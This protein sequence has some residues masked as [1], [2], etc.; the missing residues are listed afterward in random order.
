M[1]HRFGACSRLR[2]LPRGAARSS[3]LAAAVLAAVVASVPAQ[4]DP[5]LQFAE[6][7]KRQL[8]TDAEP[9]VAVARGDVDGDGDLD[10]VLASAFRRSRLYRNDGRGVF[11]DATA[12]RLPI[13]SGQGVSALALGDVDGDSDLD[14]VVGS[15]SQQSELYLN[16]GSGTFADATRLRMPVDGGAR[17]VVLGD[18]DGDGDLDL[19]VGDL[20]Q[21]RIYVNNGAGVFADATAVRMPTESETAFALALG[22]V[23]GDGDLDLI[24]AN[25]GQDRLFVNNGS[26][27][28]VDATSRWLPVDNQIA[29]A[30]A[31]GDVDG[32]GDLDLVIGTQL[33]QKRLYR[34]DG[35]GTFADVTAGRMPVDIDNTRAVVFGDVDGDGDLDLLLGNGENPGDGIAGQQNRLYRNDGTGTFTDATAG[36]LPVAR[37]LTEAAVLGDFD[38]D[39]DLDLVVGNRGQDQLHLNDGSGTF[40]DATTGR[41]PADVGAQAVALGDVDGDGD[42]D[43][44]LGS[45]NYPTGQQNRLFRNDGAGGFTDATANRLPAVTDETWSVALGDVDGDGD[46][47]LVSGN[48]GGTQG[49]QSRLYRNDGTGTFTDVTVGRLPVFAGFTSTVVLGDVDGDGDLDLVLG[50]IG[51]Q[52]RLYRNDGTGTFTDVT[53]GRLPVDSDPTFALALGDVDGDGDLDLVLGNLGLRNRLYLNN[54]AG[55]F[56]EAA[57]NRL[58]GAPYTTSSLAF[59]DVDGDGD[60]DLVVGDYGDRNRLYLNN[61]AG[62]FTDA[63]AGRLPLDDDNTRAVALG[64]LDGDGDLDLVCANFDLTNGRLNRLYRNDGAGT[65]T[66]VSLRLPGADARSRSLALGDVDRDGDLDVVLGNMLRTRLYSNLRRQLDTA[67]LLRPGQPFQLDVYSRYGPTVQSEVALPILSTARAPVAVPPFGVLGI[68]PQLPLPLVAIAPLAGVGSAVW[69][70]PNVPAIVGVEILAQAVLLRVP[71][72]L[73]L[74]N[75]TADV[76][77]R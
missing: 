28:F 59:G 60:L 17:A 43:L 44:V 19:V 51:Q 2:S 30:V 76:C 29:Q 24:A 15:Y 33:G 10:L 67:A 61:G 23:D 38:G 31:F 32:D 56:V 66:D 35:T 73:R 41:L 74:S 5:D 52:K 75:V 11:T 20:G 62:T 57:A 50:N 1:N 21:D 42:L 37:D 46:L 27:A 68:D 64:D 22:D 54:G 45:L 14:L 53:A 49:Q 13:A 47:D 4:L 48:G 18:L 39:G 3:L 69:N 70:V 34:N 25:Y 63:S 72:D 8:P 65:F 58:P 71:F 6:L 9:T 16:D 12:G 36:R 77:V 7:G 55:F 26:G 40:L